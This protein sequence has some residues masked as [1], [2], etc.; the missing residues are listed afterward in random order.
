[1]SQPP[2]PRNAGARRRRTC[3]E[4][5]TALPRTRLPLGLSALRE[6]NRV[7][8][9]AVA[10]YAEF[11]VRATLHVSRVLVSVC[12]TFGTGC[13]GGGAGP[14]LPD[15]AAEGAG[16]VAVDASVVLVQGPFVCPA[17]DAFSI[18]P[19]AVVPDQ[20]AQLEVTTVGPSPSTIQWTVSPPSGGVFSDPTAPDPAFHCGAV[21]I[22]T[23]AVQVGIVD[24]N[25]GNV[26]IGVANTSYSGLIR[27]EAAR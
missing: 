1:M 7:G 12:A 2:D 3:H 23:V 22:M 18:D 24:P 13:G 27:C 17:I 6:R 11:N 4:A 9:L 25:L 10:W 8:S 15:S 21:G 20:A 16:A 14:G 19:A 5:I 26:C